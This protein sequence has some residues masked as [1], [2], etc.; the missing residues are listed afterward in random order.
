MDLMNF[1]TKAVAQI[2]AAIESGKKEII[3]KSC[4]GSGK[5]IMLTHFMDEYLKV[6][7][8]T[9]FIWFTP[10]RARK[11]WICMFTAH[12]QNS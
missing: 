11:R 8:K 12:R 7:A 4:T 3:V 5:T 6:H 1:Q 9:V 2:M 10:S